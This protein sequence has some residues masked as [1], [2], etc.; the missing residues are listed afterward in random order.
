MA[1]IGLGRRHAD[2]AAFPAAVQL[3]LRHDPGRDTGI[4]HRQ[5][6]SGIAPWQKSGSKTLHKTFGE[7]HRGERRGLHGRSR[8]VLRHPRP[9]GCGK[10]TTLR[11]IG[12]S[13]TADLR[14]HFAG[15]RGRD[16]RL[17]A[18]ARD[19]A[20]VFQLFALYP[21]MNVRQN[22]GFPLKCQDCQ[23]RRDQ[24]QRRGDRQAIAHRS[25]AGTAG[26][27]ALRRR[28]PARCAGASHRAPAQGLSDGRAAGCARFRVSRT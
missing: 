12:G 4:Y 24:A 21:H 6:F 27:R 1:L 7:L 22:I 20:F 28:P 3:F 26:R 11:M 23:A 19:I 2:A 14:P 10:T 5:P 17:P 8:R 9:S 25:S 13:R 18:S 16:L 15:R